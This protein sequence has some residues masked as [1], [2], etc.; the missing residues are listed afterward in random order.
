MGVLVTG[1]LVDLNAGLGRE[2]LER[3]GEWHGVAL[4]HEAED[5]AAESAAKAMP[6]LAG[7]RDDERRCL[8]AVERAEPL[9]GGPRLLEA[10][11]LADHIDDGQLV[12]HFGCN[13]DRQM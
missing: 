11:R 4:H 10:D 1:S 8:L 13:A 5:V 2:R 7:G 3:L 9:V 12:L 6:G